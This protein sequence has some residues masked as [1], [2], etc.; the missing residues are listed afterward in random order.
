MRYLPYYT[1]RERLRASVL[2][3]VTGWAQVKGRNFVAWDERLALDVWYV[4]NRSLWLDLKILALTVGAVLSARTVAVDTAPLGKDL[5]E[6]R[7]S[8]EGPRP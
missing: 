4:E 8:A 3:G 7:K 5:D 1:P 6:L 2:P